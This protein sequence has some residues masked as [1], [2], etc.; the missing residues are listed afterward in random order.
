MTPAF[1]S[2]E[3]CGHFHYAEKKGYAG[4][5]VYSKAEPDAVQIGFGHPEFDAEGRYVRCDFPAI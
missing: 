3:G 5:G 2:P 4:V 1:L